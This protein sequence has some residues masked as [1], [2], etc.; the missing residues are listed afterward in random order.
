[1]R[2]ANRMLLISQ[3]LMTRTSRSA[4][5]T[6]THCGS[7]D[8]VKMGKERE[9]SPAGRRAQMWSKGLKERRELKAV[10]L[11]QGTDLSVPQRLETT[12][13]EIGPG[14]S[15]SKSGARAG[16]LAGGGSTPAQAFIVLSSAWPQDF[17]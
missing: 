12:E 5:G 10:V 11:D 16:Q 15:P 9:S 17:K 1:M 2:G 13:R 6:H 14:M 4:V 7:A 3:D 8:T